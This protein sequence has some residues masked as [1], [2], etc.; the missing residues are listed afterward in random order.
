MIEQVVFADGTIWTQQT[1]HDKMHNITGTDKDDAIRSYDNGPVE[2]HGLAGNDVLVGGRGD[3]KLYGD[4]GDDRISG[5]EGNDLIVGGRGNDIINGFRG[6]DTYVFNL[7]DGR[8][9]IHDN[10]GFDILKF[11]EGIAPEDISI[12]RVEKNSDYNLE[13]SIKNSE[14][15]VTVSNYFGSFSYFSGAVNSRGGAI[16]QVVF[17]DGTVWTVDIIHEMMHNITGTDK[18]DT[19]R[20]YDDD[21]VEYHGLAGNDVLVGGR[22]NDKLYGDDGNDT[23]YGGEGNDLLV[24]GKGDDELS[25][26]RGDDTYIFNRGDGS[27]MISECGGIDTIKFG[28]GIT[29]DD[30]DVKRVYK[31]GSD[32]G[33][34][35]ELSLKGT[36]DKISVK[37]YF[38]YYSYSGFHK[39]S[40]ESLIE[41]VVF[42]DGTVWTQDTINS[43]VHNITGTEDSETIQAFDD[44]AVTYYGLGGND[45]LYGSKSNDKLYG[46]AGNDRISGGEGDDL[47]VGGAGD[48]YLD[49]YYGND[50]YIFNKGDGSDTVYDADGKDD[51]IVLGYDSQDIMF[52]RFGNNLRLRITGSTDSVTIDSWYASSNDRY[53]IETFKSTTGSTITHTQIENLIQAMSSFQKDTGMTWEQALATQPSQVQA[54]VQEYWTVPGV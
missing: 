19:I 54:I 2:Y 11:G 25:G 50:T 41:K 18:D 6:D 49:G 21:S 28:E 38:G 29:P 39:P 30:V 15:S 42:A 34:A 5:E 46:G 4:D 43:K 32:Y 44:D 47:I 20:F 3:D 14:D 23:I 8:D 26:S 51:K 17:A 10:Y 7:G 37:N 45:N 48:D 9:I 1:I 53:K 24:G 36:S 12:K 31:S 27:D 22:G 13:L 35:L 33:Y 52:E 40:P 16:D